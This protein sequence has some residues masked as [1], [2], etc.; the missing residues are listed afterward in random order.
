MWCVVRV[1]RAKRTLSVT[2]TV[3]YTYGPSLRNNKASGKYQKLNAPP[4]RN[5]FALLCGVC[6]VVPVRCYCFGASVVLRGC[7]QDANV[8]FLHKLQMLAKLA[9]GMNKPNQQTVLPTSHVESVFSS[10][11]LKKV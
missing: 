8:F 2:R 5:S 10:T 7:E 1:V 4:A 11:P 6:I 9:A 3:R